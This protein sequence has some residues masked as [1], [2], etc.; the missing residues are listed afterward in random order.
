MPDFVRAV[1]SAFEPRDPELRQDHETEKG[2]HRSATPM[3][4][5]MNN[6]AV[7]PI[8]QGGLALV[9]EGYNTLTP[10]QAN[11]VLSRYGYGKNR[12]ISKEHVQ[13]LAEMMRRGS[14]LP[15][16]TISFGRLPNGGLV[17]VNGHHRMAAQVEAA[18]HIM[19][20]VV[21]HDCADDEE[22][23]ALYYRYDTNVRKRSDENI[24]AAVG[25]G[26]GTEL[27]K[28]W[29]R[30]IWRAAP[31]I[32]SGLQ[33]NR[34]ARMSMTARIT[35]DRLEIAQDYIKEGI[36]LGEALREMP[37]YLRRKM[38]SGP[39]T[40]IALTIMR[41]APQDG[42]AFFRTIAEN[43]R[44]PRDDPRSAFLNWLASYNLRGGPETSGTSRTN[45][46]VE[47]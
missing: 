5:T 6:T 27:K 24:L 22:V 17:M 30:A 20:N 45:F 34:A 12:R 32:A 46:S 8:E 18:A 40:A 47:T 35:D 41:A 43:D 4:D 26:E 38:Q 39:I 19:W 29:R 42:E 28:E 3:D 36:A 25:F 14:W 13:T 23:S 9:R 37:S 44:L 1:L 21:I 16:D 7:H 2:P 11:A 15:K 10:A 31:I 33:A